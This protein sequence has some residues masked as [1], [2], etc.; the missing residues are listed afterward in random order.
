MIYDV[1]ICH[2]VIELN[3]YQIWV[4]IKLRY[5]RPATVNIE[6]D[7]Q[8]IEVGLGAK[9]DLHFCSFIGQ[10]SVYN[11]EFKKFVSYVRD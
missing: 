3:S 11:S 8:L 5:L 4:F 2:D 1:P 9:S 7:T 6:P 10:S